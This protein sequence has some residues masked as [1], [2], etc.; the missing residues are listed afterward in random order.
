MQNRYS[1][2][3]CNAANDTDQ[4]EAIAQARA[5]AKFN[6]QNGQEDVGN[7]PGVTTSATG[8]SPD[9]QWEVVTKRLVEATDGTTSWRYPR[10]DI[11][12]YDHRKVQNVPASATPVEI[13]EVKGDWNGTASDAAQQAADYADDFGERAQP[14]SFAENPYNDKFEVDRTYLN[15]CASDEDEVQTYRAKG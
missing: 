5:I 7:R 2:N 15:D 9:I 8:V 14:R 3:E 13:V 10:A 12:M 6:L 11:V 4:I 1:R